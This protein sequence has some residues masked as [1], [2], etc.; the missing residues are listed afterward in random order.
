MWK[1]WLRL[2][3]I[4]LTIGSLVYCHK[5]PGESKVSSAEEEL[6]ASF[7]PDA[8]D[9]PCSNKNI[10]WRFLR[11]GNI[12]CKT[13]INLDFFDATTGEPLVG[14]IYRLVL[15]VYLRIP[16]KSFFT[17]GDTRN[18]T[19]ELP[20]TVAFV[21][22]Q[23]SDDPKGKTPVYGIGKVLPKVTYDVNGL[24]GLKIRDFSIKVTEV[25]APDLGR[26]ATRVG[27]ISEHL[28]AHYK[29]SVI[30]EIQSQIDA[31]GRSRLCWAYRQ[32]F[33]RDGGTKELEA[34]APAPAERETALR[35]INGGAGPTEADTA[36]IDKWTEEK[37]KEFDRLWN[38]AWTGACL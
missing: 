6:K 15:D 23:L 16:I 14:A 5:K 36:E 38:C 35:V 2:T 24:C 13:S 19:I 29:S 30:S 8:K 7:S 22:A 18:R 4:V 21:K 33:Y 26:F 28:V 27:S 37:Y 1:W 17:A 9:L 11:T 32:V 20:E 12:E 25:K 34:V 31:V 3:G 10:F